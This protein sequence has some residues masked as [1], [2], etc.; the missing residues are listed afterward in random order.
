MAVTFAVGLKACCVAVG[1]LMVTAARAAEPVSPLVGVT[2]DQLLSRYGEPKSQI[3]TGNRVVFFYPREK[4]ILRDNVVVEVEQ[5]AG[6]S[7]PPPTAPSETSPTD[8][9][10]ATPAVPAAGSPESKVEI[11]LVRPP[12]SKDNR[13]V[14][15]EA[16]KAP[17]TVMP[18]SPAPVVP[19]SRPAIEQTAPKSPP[20][21]VERAEEVSQRETTVEPT[22]SDVAPPK[23][24]AEVPS[25]KTT[26]AEPAVTT[27]APAAPPPSL[28]P[29]DGP[30]G[31]RTYLIVMA[32]VL[33]GAGLLFWKYRQR[34]I[35]LAASSVENTP[36]TT[37]TTPVFT[38]SGFS[39]DILAKLEWRRFEE[40]VVA[41]YSKTGVV[42]V[43]T[44]TGPKSPV[45]IKISWKGEP[46]PFAYV[47]CIAQ[48]GGL[49]DPKPL[50]ALV[51][52]LAADD[53][54]RGYV[55]TPGKFN[56]VARDLAEEKHLTLLPGEVFLEKLNALPPGARAEIMQ[57]VSTGDYTVPSC[58]RCEAKMVQSTD[59]PPVWRCPNHP[60]E[61][62]PVRV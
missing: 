34:Q 47:Q 60:E 29:I 43:R 42:A 39:A 46:R 58:P 14:T 50:Q 45:H 11:K 6:E 16:P 30:I 36:L 17:V 31:T 18:S 10:P 62:L 25:V 57:S 1:L 49:I 38:G 44:K 59:D 54:R 13:P 22:K 9:S 15:T 55:V 28:P 61:T 33:G 2:R 19:Q 35:E 5:L 37:P 23:K 32:V 56:V 48:P 26:K 3:E 8:A 12:G 20:E 52:A 21:P 53:I 40:L 41:Y 24:A 51:A 4:I 27:P 7:A